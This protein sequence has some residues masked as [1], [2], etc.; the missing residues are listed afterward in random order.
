MNLLFLANLIL[1]IPITSKV[2]IQL[3]QGKAIIDPLEFHSNAADGKTFRIPATINKLWYSFLA[4][5]I[6]HFDKRY[7]CLNTG[8]DLRIP[9][10]FH[11]DQTVFL[12]CCHCSVQGTHF[13]V[14]EEVDASDEHALHVQV[15]DLGW[16]LVAT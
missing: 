12:F 4:H 14:A 5:F 2:V 16:L 7:F 9:G 13:L 3:C 10:G 11:Q 15:G 1:G 6:I 8:L